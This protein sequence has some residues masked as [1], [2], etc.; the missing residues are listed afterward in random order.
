MIPYIFGTEYARNIYTTS[1]R[2]CSERR[3]AIDYIENNICGCID[4]NKIAMIVCQSQINFQRTF[5]IMTDISVNEYIRKRRMTL[6]AFELQNS[7][8]KV[9]D[10]AMKY[11]YESP[12]A[13]TRA[14]KEI[15]GVSPTIAR[16]EG[17]QLKSFSRITFLLTIKGVET[18]K[19]GRFDKLKKSTGGSSR[20][21]AICQYRETGGN[22]FPY[23]L[24]AYK[25]K[26]S[27]T[28]GF[29]EVVVPAAT[30][31]I[32][33]TYNYKVEETSSAIQ[34]LNK[35]VYTEWLPTAN[36]EK[37]DGYELELYYDTDDGL[38]YSETWIRVM[39]K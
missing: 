27:K 11:G 24:Y 14:F 22:T 35:R 5:S 29:A 4:F 23:M 2:L 20:I 12:E 34:D 39:P 9:I 16:E 28:D 33:R 17:I 10:I 7:K 21:H 6:A 38:C 25:S 32:F 13:F 15:H 37:V 1:V 18:M 31:A 26:D 8:V 3:Y 36:Y 30:W 19:D